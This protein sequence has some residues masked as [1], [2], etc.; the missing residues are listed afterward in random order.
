MAEDSAP[1]TTPSLTLGEALGEYLKSLKPE[2]RRTQESHLWKYVRDT[3]E[4]RPLEFLSGSRIESYAA[5][6]IRGS[7]PN[8]PEHV[9]AL[10]AWFQYLKK[11]GHTEQNFGIHIRVPKGAARSSGPR[12][13]RVEDAPIE[14]TAEGIEKLKEELHGLEQSRQETIS[15]VE[16]ARQDGD[17]R[18]NAPYHAAREELSFTQQRISELE[19][20]L[21]RAV[22]VGRGGGDSSTVGSRVTVTRLDKGIQ[23]TYQLVSAQEANARER[24]I[25]VE[26]P[27]GREL[28]GKKAGDQVSVSTP[29]GSVIDYSIEDVKHG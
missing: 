8:A 19:D 20:A 5:E 3:G 2:Q 15:A 23:E 29:S 18:E 6:R 16:L 1:S 14:M 7:D 28:L 9:A 10:K 25:S 26:S 12:Q 24:R 11:K 13:V 17:L 22:T 21:K 27:V 4:S